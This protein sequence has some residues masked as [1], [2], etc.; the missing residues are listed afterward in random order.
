MDN[1]MET[2][3]ESV[4]V[5]IDELKATRSAYIQKYEM[6]PGTF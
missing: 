3:I 2:E 6:A 1:Q 4:K 5:E